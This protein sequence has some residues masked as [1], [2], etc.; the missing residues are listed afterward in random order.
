MGV[1]PSRSRS[2]QEIDG[3]SLSQFGLGA[4]ICGW[5]PID[6]EWTSPFGQHYYYLWQSYTTYI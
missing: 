1:A 6:S 5:A 3:I 2:N 4:P